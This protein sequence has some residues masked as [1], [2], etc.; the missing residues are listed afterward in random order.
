MLIGFALIVK[1]KV[2]EKVGYLDERFNPGNFEDDDL[3][4]R[5]LMNN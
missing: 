3:S 1:R 4:L 2:L 5:I